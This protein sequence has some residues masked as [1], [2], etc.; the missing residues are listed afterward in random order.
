MYPSRCERSIAA[1]ECSLGPKY[2][3]PAAPDLA[4][5]SLMNESY[6]THSRRRQIPFAPPND[7]HPPATAVAAAA[8]AAAAGPGIL[9]HGNKT[10]PRRSPSPHHRAR[11]FVCPVRRPARAAPSLRGPTPHAGGWGAH[12]ERA[13]GRT[14]SATRAVGRPARWES[15]CRAL[16]VIPRS[17]S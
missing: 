13:H 11:R 3:P 17:R 14:P 8:A 1:G 10:P 6:K 4:L 16:S 7:P 15:A 5:H 12:H 2:R 9:A